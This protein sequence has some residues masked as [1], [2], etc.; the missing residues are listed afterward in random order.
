MYRSIQTLLFTIFFVTL[1]HAQTAVNNSSKS[2]ILTPFSTDE[3][4]GKPLILNDV[5]ITGTVYDNDTKEP[6]EYATVS[7]FNKKENKIETGGITDAKG[8]FKI[9]VKAG[10]YDINIEYISYITKTIKNRILTQN[11]DLG[12]FYLEINLEA[13]QAVEII[14]ESTTVEIKLDKKIYNVGKD[15]T[16]RGGTV[17]DVLDNVPSVSVDVEGNVSLRGND[18]VR[19]LINGKPSGLVGLNSTDALRQLPA[20]SIERVEVITSPSARYDAEGTAGILNIILRRSKLQGLNGAMTANAGHPNAAGISG[21][22]NYRTGNFNFFNTS[23]YSY[24]ESPGKSITETEYFN[25]NTFLNEDRIYDRNR[26]GLNTNLGMEWYINDTSSLTS[27]F[28]YRDSDQNQ[29]ATNTIDEL[30]NVGNLINRSIRFDPEDETDKT[31]Q[32]SINFD[33]QFNG[34]SEHK[35]TFDFQYESSFEDEKSLISQDG[36]DAER[37]ETI[38]QQDRIL[39]QTDYV[40]PIGE[41]SQFELGYRGNFNEL[42]TDYSLEFNENGTFVLD[43]DVSNNLIYR[44]YV[45]A[46]YSQFGSKIKNKFSYLL[47]LRL[48]ETRI[49]IDQITSG[50]FEK[51]NY[52]GLFPTVNLGYEITEN[53]SITLGYNRRIQRPRSR[54]INPFPSRTSAT[55]LFQGNPDIDPSYSNKIDFGYLNKFGKTTLN[56][57]VYFERATDVFTFIVEDTG[58]TAI[59]GGTAIPVIRRSPINLA[60]NDRFGFEFTLTYRPSQKWN[61]NGNFNLFQSKTSGSFNGVDYGAENVS[62]F[63]RINNKYTLP[64]NIDWQTRIFYMGPREDAQNKS[65]GMFSTDLAFSK[66]FLN[67]KASIAF[68]VSDLFNSRKRQTTSTTSTFRSYS[69][70]QWRQRSF[71]ISLTYRFNQQKKRERNGGGRENGG[72]D[73][74][75]EG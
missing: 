30:G 38:E 15:L 72:E 14:A 9:E 56:S 4:S 58:E 22:I 47:G 29:F 44:E 20:E 41:K 23:G 55:N 46:F 36:N 65:K 1:N 62:W 27:S 75:V 71:N 31:T 45:N 64:G 61:L 63:A 12:K 52:L 11:E 69:E 53:Q 6:L 7:F 13:L 40:L 3:P 28:L 49:T 10:V 5:I 21:N 68:N 42:D 43:T 51:K 60:T 2:N 37:V 8:N 74:D 16:V 32:Y 54:F 34:N 57:S 25:S 17:S 35:L 67:E 70:F 50:D 59:V 18:N 19:I 26:K 48:E 73:F 39:L 66:D 33:K 24:S